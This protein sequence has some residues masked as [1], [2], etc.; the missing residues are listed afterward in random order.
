[1]NQPNTSDRPKRSAQVELARVICCAKCS[2]PITKPQHATT[3]DGDH[4]RTFRNPGGYS[5]HVLCFAQAEG[6]DVKGRPTT[7][8]SWFADTAWAFAVC[9][10]CGQHLGWQYSRLTGEPFF[11]LIAPRLTGWK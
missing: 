1:V 5:F 2:H 6:C 3:V 4:Q 8:A 7:D 10:G 11:G 9:Q